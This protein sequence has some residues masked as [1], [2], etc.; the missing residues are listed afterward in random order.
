MF[1]NVHIL[2]RSRRGRG[3][4]RD[5]GRG[6]GQSSTLDPNYNNAIDASGPS[7]YNDDDDQKKSAH[8]EL[9]RQRRQEMSNLYS[10]LRSE[11]PNE[12]IRVYISQTSLSIN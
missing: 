12:Y 2:G 5:R 3:R 4:G 7:N 6:R 11:L 1:N 10:S 9:E 8:R